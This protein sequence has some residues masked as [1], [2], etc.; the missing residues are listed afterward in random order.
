MSL[1][2]FFLENQNFGDE[3]EASADGSVTLSLSAEDLHHAKV[4]RLKV[5]EHIGVIDSK[6]AYY[7]CE[8]VDCQKE[9]IVKNVT[10]PPEVLSQ[11]ACPEMTKPGRRLW[12]CQGIAKGSKFDEVVRDCTEIG[13][14]G[15]IPVEFARS[16]AKLDAKKEATKIERWQKIAKSAAMQSG[17]FAIPKISAAVDVKTLCDQLTDFDCVFIC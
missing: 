12:L 10:V 1:Q 2:H 15:F 6:Q 13:V 14:Y 9:L 5:G 3:V 16:V 17:Q 11:G 4:L 7:R 8:V